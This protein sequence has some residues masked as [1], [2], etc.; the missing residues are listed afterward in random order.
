MHACLKS[1][2]TFRPG[3]TVAKILCFSGTG[4]YNKN[5]GCFNMSLIDNFITYK[6][7]TPMRIFMELQ[8]I[9]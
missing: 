6:L 2:S 4:N 8:A 5:S 1:L 7:S 9:T 3:I